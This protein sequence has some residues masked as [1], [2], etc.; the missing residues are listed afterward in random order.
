MKLE[1]IRVELGRAFSHIRRE[2]KVLNRAQAKAEFKAGR[3]RR[4]TA[5]LTAGF[6][7]G[8]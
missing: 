7:V 6:G 3:K 5:G 1:K 4:R 2:Q 8:G